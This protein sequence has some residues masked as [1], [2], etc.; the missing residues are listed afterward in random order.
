MKNK[1]KFIHLGNKNEY[2]SKQGDISRMRVKT[3][4]GNYLDVFYNKKN[5]LFVADVID[6]NFKG[7]NEFVRANLNNIDIVSKKK[8]KLKELAG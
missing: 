3:K 6:K 5:D 1:N 4:Q 2:A 8:F 7:G